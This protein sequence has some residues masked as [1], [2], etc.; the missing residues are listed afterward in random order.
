[1]VWA[2]MVRHVRASHKRTIVYVRATH[3]RLIHVIARHA[4]VIYSRARYVRQG[5]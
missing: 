4:S 5:M 2:V 3:L 1:M